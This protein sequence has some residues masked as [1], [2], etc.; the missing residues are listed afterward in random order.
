[1]MPLLPLRLEKSQRVLLRRLDEL[2][3]WSDTVLSNRP[4]PDGDIRHVM[5][6]RLTGAVHR[7][8]RA[9][10]A[11]VRGGSVDALEGRIRTILEAYINTQYILADES[12]MR[13]YAFLVDDIR[14]RKKLCS[15][16][17]PIFKKSKAHSMATISDLKFWQDQ[18]LNLSAELRDMESEY[19]ADNLKWPNLLER[20][21]EI[22]AEE[23]YATAY[24]QFSNDE[25]LS[26]RYLNRFTHESNG[27]LFFSLEHDLH[28]L[29]S[30]LQMAYIWYVAFLNTCNEHFGFPPNEDLKG[31][32]AIADQLKR[33]AAP[34]LFAAK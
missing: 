6:F 15:W 30:I 23:L 19:G 27:S 3:T 8:I 11:Q 1:M 4:I 28:T 14:S 21:K 12:G 26:E 16:M 17:I 9:I 2:W 10:L 20:A 13:A 24:W 22:D 31:Y 33:A 32:N 25:H 29:E 7:L 5:L 34:R 18:E